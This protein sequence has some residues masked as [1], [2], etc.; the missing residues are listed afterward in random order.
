[1]KTLNVEM[2]VTPKTPKKIRKGVKLLLSALKITDAKP[3][4]LSFT[5]RSDTYLNSFCFKNCEDEKKKTGCEIIYGWS[6]W[7]DRKN[8]FFE[9]EFH[10]VIEE[11]GVLVDI[12]PR[13]K[14]EKYI[15][16]VTDMSRISGRK[17]IDSWYS[18]SNLKMVDGNVVEAS[19]E[20]EVVQLD[21]ESSEFRN[22]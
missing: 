1:M 11:N 7:E 15:L 22:V 16:F 20:L 19:E 13:P 4:Y 6:L 12:T 10:S 5:H 21:A 17:S 9:A 3:V 18:W 2:T 14:N 8:K